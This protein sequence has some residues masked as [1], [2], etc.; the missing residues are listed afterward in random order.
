MPAVKGATDALLC[1][2]E[3]VALRAVLS[4]DRTW[5]LV[6]TVSSPSR[7]RWAASARQARSLSY[8]M[9]GT[10]AVSPKPIPL[11]SALGILNR[12]SEERLVGKEGISPP[13]GCEIVIGFSSVP[14]LDL[15][16]TWEI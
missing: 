7:L 5:G 8:G 10:P 13:T 4:A 16:A 6:R 1:N 3:E 2:W 11:P 14:A 9:A 12:R 15:I